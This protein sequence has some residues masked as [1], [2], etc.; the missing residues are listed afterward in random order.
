MQAKTDTE[1]AERMK[2]TRAQLTDDEVQRIAVDAAELERL[3]GIPNSPEALANLPQLQVSDLPEKP[4]HIPTTA[5][6][7]RDQVL[8]RNDVFANGVNYLVL[9][10]DLQGLPEQLWTHL[11]RYADAISKLGAADMSYEE[12]AQRTSSVTG[13]IGCA[14]CFL[15][16]LSTQIVPC[17]VCSFTLKRLITEWMRRWT[18]C[19]IYF[20]R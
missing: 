10:F 3:N 19:T 2:E 17:S 4:K 14:P 16:T 6:N 1:L 7:V 12:M 20:S 18:S 8:L 11:P 9:N 13:G 15:Q 5:E